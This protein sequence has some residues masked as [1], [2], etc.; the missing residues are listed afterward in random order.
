MQGRGWQGPGVGLVNTLG[1][2]G[3]G[4]MPRMQPDGIAAVRRV[5]MGMNH[6]RRTNGWRRCGRWNVVSRKFVLGFWGVGP[7]KFFQQQLGLV[8]I[9]L[10]VSNEHAEF[11]SH[12]LR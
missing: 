2:G 9:V 6:R 4:R 5:R 12:F 11:D 10:L 8:A 3:D 7:K 1:Q